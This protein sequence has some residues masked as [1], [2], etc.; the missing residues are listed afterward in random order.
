MQ[1]YFGNILAS[2]FFYWSCLQRMET[3][4]HL[5]ALFCGCASTPQ[6]QTKKSF[7]GFLSVIH[8][9]CVYL[10]FPADCPV[11]CQHMQRRRLQAEEK[12]FRLN[13]SS[14]HSVCISPLLWCTVYWMQS[15]LIAGTLKT[16]IK[17]NLPNVDRLALCQTARHWCPQWPSCNLPMCCV[18][19]CT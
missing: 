12:R 13:I 19:V 17:T 9:R 11:R 7:E 14:T 6:T 16:P 5:T 10:Q 15:V 18:N 3:K 2:L 1:N 4:Q 8:T